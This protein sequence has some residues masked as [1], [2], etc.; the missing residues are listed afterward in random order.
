MPSKDYRMGK[1]K[2]AEAETPG[3][4]LIGGWG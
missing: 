1:K 4:R 3:Y 2:D